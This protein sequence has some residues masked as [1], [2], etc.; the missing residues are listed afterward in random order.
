MVSTVADIPIGPPFPDLMTFN[1]G[2]TLA[3]YGIG[4]GWSPSSRLVGFNKR[5]TN[6]EPHLIDAFWN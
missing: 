3:E 6:S 2:G 1:K 5:H 4:P